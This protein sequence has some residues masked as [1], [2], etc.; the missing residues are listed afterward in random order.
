MT[1]LLRAIGLILVLGVAGCS[2]DAKPT[3]TARAA[4]DHDDDD[5]NAPPL[6]AAKLTDADARAIAQARIAGE[7]VDSELEREH[8]HLI[9]SI[10][11]RPTGQTK[12]V[13]EV[14][15]DAIDGS[16]VNV[17]DEDEDDEGAEHEGEGGHDDHEDDDED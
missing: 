14:N 6:S 10:E 8:G 7:I 11:I 3:T 15:V 2:H 17:E 16:I 12:G 5:S 1:P 4:S 9:Y 13:K